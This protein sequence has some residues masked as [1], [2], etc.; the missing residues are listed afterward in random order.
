MALTNWHNIIISKECL[1]KQHYLC[2]DTAAG[3]QCACGCNVGQAESRMSNPRRSSEC[4]RGT[5]IGCNKL[6]GVPCPC[7]CHEAFLGVYGRT[8]ACNLNAHVNCNNKHGACGCTCHANQQAITNA[9]QAVG[10][11]SNRIGIQG[12]SIPQTPSPLNISSYCKA[13]QHNSCVYVLQCR[14]SC[15]NGPN[16]VIQGTPAP[17]TITGRLSTDNKP[18]LVN[19]PISNNSK[20][21]Y[22]NAVARMAPIAE[23]IKK[24]YLLDT[25]I[26]FYFCGETVRESLFGGLVDKYKVYV[27]FLTDRSFSPFIYK[28]L[29]QFKDTDGNYILDTKFGKIVVEFVESSYYPWSCDSYQYSLDKGAYKNSTKIGILESNNTLALNDTWKPSKDDSPQEVLEYGIKQAQL[30][31]WTIEQASIEKLAKAIQQFSP[32]N[33]THELVIGFRNYNLIN[34]PVRNGGTNIYTLKGSHGPWP[35]ETLSVDCPNFEE[36]V[37]NVDSDWRSRSGYAN[38][39]GQHDCGIYVYKDPSECLFHYGMYNNDSVNK[40]M[41][42]VYCWGVIGEFEHGYRVQHCQIARL[43]IWDKDKYLTDSYKIEEIISGAKFSDFLYD[44]EVLQ[45][46]DRIKE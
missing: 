17:S 43:W 7:R 34:N 4:A 3:C 24:Q 23:E 27:S 46:A 37:K 8:H 36:H 16:Y 44:K 35:T 45:F 19:M 14:C 5:H 15:H 12:V 26:A 25:D 33:N 6:N 29:E 41:A 39:N 40:A 9:A 31:G 18:P 28:H 10:Y 30:H 2:M 20:I 22:N 13:A 38:T 1:T 42:L 21:N 32:L 11:N